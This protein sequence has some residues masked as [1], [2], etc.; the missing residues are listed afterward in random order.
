[1]NKPDLIERVSG[2]SGV[3]KRQAEE[4]LEAF[5]ST[6]RSAVKQ[7][8]KVAW[9]NF[10]SFS[11][12]QRKGRTGRN[13]RTGEP[14]KIPA[15]KSVKFSPGTSLR[16]FLNTGRGGTKAGASKAG[17]TKGGAAKGGAA[18]KAGGAKRT[19][20]ATKAGGAAKG[21]AAKGGTAKKAPAT[22]A[23]RKR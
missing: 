22:K 19:A 17:A 16:E 23:T 1:M 9:P 6:V 13:P 2:A 3:A 14:V 8:D 10:G 20:P 7:G 15:S 11:L 18:S 12:S 21:G 4:V 5:F